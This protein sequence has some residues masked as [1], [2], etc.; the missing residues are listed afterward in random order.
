MNRHIYEKIKNYIPYNEREA[1]D[2]D[3]ILKFIE[4]KEDVLTR[5]N[6]VAHF[7]VSSWIINEERTKVLMI[8]HNIYKSWSWIGGHVDGESDFLA[9]ARREAGEE[10]GLKET[11]LLKEDFIGL[12][13]LTVEAHTRRGEYV[14]AHLHFDVEY[15]FEARESLPIR[16]KEDENS[17]VGWIPLEE[18]ESYI[19]EEKMKPIYRILIEKVSKL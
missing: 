2:K 14:N 8:Y 9:V 18:V 19:A 4:E 3:V 10:T 16:V 12:N 5:N 7:T 13:V 6:K 1:C 17:E 15:I 11:N